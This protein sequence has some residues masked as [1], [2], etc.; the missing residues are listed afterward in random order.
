MDGKCRKPLS[1]L[2]FAYTIL[3]MM[4]EYSNEFDLVIHSKPQ[5]QYTILL[6]AGEE[7]AYA[8]NPL[9]DEVYT[10]EFPG[11]PVY[12][13]YSRC[14]HVLNHHHI[15]M[16]VKQKLRIPSHC[17]LEASFWRPI[18]ILCFSEADGI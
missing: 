9:T 13:L 2:N 16:L 12:K 3:R 14:G 6:V 8:Y 5:L 7:Y 15:R 18:S 1:G 4:N 10:A 17:E 11:I